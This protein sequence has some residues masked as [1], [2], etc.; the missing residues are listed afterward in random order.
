[1][2]HAVQLLPGKATANSTSE[3]SRLMTN[4]GSPLPSV[5]KQQVEAGA[6]WLL[7]KASVL[8]IVHDGR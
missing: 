8:C 7:V 3:P 4:T 5:D 2:N 1:M 6:S